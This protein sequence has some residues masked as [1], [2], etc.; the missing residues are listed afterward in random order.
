V[1]EGDAAEMIPALLY[2]SAC[3]EISNASFGNIG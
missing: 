1:Y 2:I 3:F